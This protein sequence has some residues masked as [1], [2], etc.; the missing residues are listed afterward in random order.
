M[1]QADLELLI[2]AVAYLLFGYALGLAIARNKCARQRGYRWYPPS[3][4][5]PP[6]PPPAPPLFAHGWWRKWPATTEEELNR[7]P[8][9]AK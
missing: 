2:V 5:E 9:E 3:E 7:R 8:P 1:T 6:P 4:K